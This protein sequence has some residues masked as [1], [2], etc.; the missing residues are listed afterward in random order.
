MSVI[1]ELPSSPVRGRRRTARTPK[2]ALF[3]RLFGFNALVFLAA[4]AVLL[5][6]PATVSTHASLTEIGVVAVGSALM[7]AVNALLLRTSLRPLDGLTTLMER[8]DLL[9][10][11]AR[12][13][14]QGD[15]DV[16]HL[17]RTF[18]EMLDRLEHERGASSA[19]ALAA[20]ESER[21]RI[22]RE[23]HDEIGQ[24]LTAVLLGLKRTI[25]RAPGELRAELQA[26]QEMIR[27]CLD[28]VRMVARR[29][30]PGV[31]EDLGLLSAMHALAADFTAVST[32]QVTPRLEQALP[33][34]SK[35]TE[36]VLYRIT[37][38]GLTNITRHAAASHVD[39]ELTRGAGNVTLLISDDGRGMNGASEGAGIRGM[40]ERAILIDADLTLSPVP[41]GGTELRLVVPTTTTKG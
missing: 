7:L 25:D 23:L 24:S 17:I 21:Q 8:V 28:E 33:L 40:R 18:N 16:A 1:A 6:S 9:R 31:L 34:L 29:L 3:W 39:L 22:A 11:G 19:H 12:M 38:E 26:V 2:S 32:I 14:V 27:D 41:T 35:D 37:Q 15:R 5:L 36:L 4:A 10:P 20:Q 30:R 13:S